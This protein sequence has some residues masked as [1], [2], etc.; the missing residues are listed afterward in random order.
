MYTHWFTGIYVIIIKTMIFFFQ[1]SLLYLS[2]YIIPI[3]TLSIPQKKYFSLDIY[4]I[5]SW[6]DNAVAI[7]TIIK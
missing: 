1:F 7:F 5:F 3:H 2:V 4:Y 6:E